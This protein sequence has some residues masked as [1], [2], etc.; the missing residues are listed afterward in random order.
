MA[1]WC[2]A[3]L[4]PSDDPTYVGR[5]GSV[6]SR[7]ANFALQNSDFLLAIGVRLDFS[8]TG[9]APQNLARE[10]YKIAVD[11]DPAELRK[12]E[13]HL[14]QPVC[15]D[16]GD[17]MKELLNQRDRIERRSFQRWFDRCADWKTRYPIVTAEHRQPA[18]LVSIFNL[19]DVIGTEVSPNDRL[20]VGNSGSGIEIFL[21]AFPTLH[22]QRMYHTA[23]LGAMGFAIPNAIAV[24]IANPGC[25]VIAVDGDGGFML[26]IQDLETIHRSAVANQV[27]RVEQQWL[28]LDPRV[29]EELLWGRQY[30]RRSQHG[31]DDSRSHQGERQLRPQHLH[32]R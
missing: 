27:L 18:G 17:F 12:L 24:A 23:G 10:A 4:V 22:S 5:P 30:R 25:E 19:A 26:N 31:A 8:I 6:A 2:A 16:A 11:V 13:P 3:D 1:T 7:G 32:H 29:A 28:Q 21:L 14:Q 20:V 9:Y 15:C